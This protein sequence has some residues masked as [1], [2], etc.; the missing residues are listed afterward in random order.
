MTKS[1]DAGLPSATMNA[2]RDRIIRALGDSFLARNLAE[3]SALYDQ[4]EEE[5]AAFCNE[6]HVHCAFGCG[7][8]CEHFV[9]DI[10]P[11]E[12]RMV[13]AYL[14]L[15]SK[16]LSLIDRVQQPVSGHCPLY[17]PATPYHC[18]VYSARPLIC[19]LFAQCASRAKTG[20]AL[21]RRCKFNDQET[22]PQSLSFPADSG[23][24]TMDDYGMQLRSLSG[25]EG[26]DVEDLNVAVTEALSAVQMIASYTG[27][28]G[29]DD[30]HDNDDSTPSPKA[31]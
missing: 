9:P 1:P 10:T 13:A 3:L 7:T 16:N 6:H 17:D 15:V 8:C 11:S 27:A 25:G 14:L 29:S 21:F 23:V 19:R 26:D 12:A 20:E 5:T 4:I 2:E 24:K 22:M 30:G 28:L 31:S 18:Q